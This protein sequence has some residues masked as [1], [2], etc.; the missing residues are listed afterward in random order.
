[1]EK[2]EMNLKILLPFQVF[3][4]TKNVS[5]IEVE[6]SRG[7]FCLF[8]QRLDCVEILIPGIF[9]YETETDGVCHLAVDEGVLVKSGTQVLMSVRR[10]IRGSELSHL[11]QTVN[12]EFR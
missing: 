9:T 6:T 1:M 7:T 12:K 11:R 2:K 8:P 4:E 10:A 5:R 3:S